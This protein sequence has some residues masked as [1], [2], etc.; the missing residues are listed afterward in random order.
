MTSINY[1]YRGADSRRGSVVGIE[2]I[3][4]SLSG[5]CFGTVSVSLHMSWWVGSSVFR[6]LACVID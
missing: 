1:L 5:Q 3:G 4:P 2:E 6:N